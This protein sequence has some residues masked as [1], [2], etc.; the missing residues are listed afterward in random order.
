MSARG[1]RSLQL[2]SR[3]PEVI[4]GSVSGYLALVTVGAWHSVLVGRTRTPLDRDVRHRFCVLI[5]AHNEE[6]LIGST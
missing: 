1:W 2:V 6:R 5:P 4:L 3:V